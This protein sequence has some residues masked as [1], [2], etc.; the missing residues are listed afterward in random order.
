[1]SEALGNVCEVHAHT[2][3]ATLGE[4]PTDGIKP[5]GVIHWVSASHGKNAQVRL[6]ERLFN[7][8]VPDKGDN[9]FMD[10]INL[11]RPVA[12]FPR[13]STMVT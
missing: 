12:S 10:H 1:M 5:K 4:N 11:S 9:A 3:A 7:H 6:Y 8:E 2:I 13:Q